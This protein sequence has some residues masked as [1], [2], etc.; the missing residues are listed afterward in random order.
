MAKR[1]I[2]RSGDSFSPDAKSCPIDVGELTILLDPISGGASYI[3]TRAQ[4]EAEGIVPSNT[5]WPDR[6]ECIRW[7]DG[8]NEF[9]L[10]RDRPEGAKGPR[11][12]FLKCDNWR[13]GIL[14]RNWNPF[15]HQIMRKTEELRKMIHRDSRAG[16][17]AFGKFWDALQVA[18][19]D[20]KFQAFKALVPGLVPEPR[21]CRSGSPTKA[22]N[23]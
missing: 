9:W 3:G 20:Q 16:R 19:D 6:F 5:Q 1:E 21:T 11:R 22:Q 18:R 4:I 12:D 14:R 2:D 13:L 23:S 17:A 8:D 15:D 7:T 10:R